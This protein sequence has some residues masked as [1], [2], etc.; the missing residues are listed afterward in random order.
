MENMEATIHG[1]PIS[2]CPPKQV[3]YYRRLLNAR[4]ADLLKRMNRGGLSNVVLAVRVVQVV[5]R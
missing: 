3:D 2:Q 5:Q 1:K 4:K